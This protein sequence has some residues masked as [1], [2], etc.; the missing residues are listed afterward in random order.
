MS[1]TPGPW[2]WAAE[3]H[4]LYGAGPNN[5]VLAYYP[6]EGMHLISGDTA[7]NARLIAAA[8]DL[9]AALRDC[10]A[11]I[12]N[13]CPLELLGTCAPEA[14]AAAAAIAKATGATA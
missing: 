1:A 6:C 4:G 7:A 2:I 5:A 12:K 10:L 11:W 14:R 13:D 3:Y 9:L 8:P